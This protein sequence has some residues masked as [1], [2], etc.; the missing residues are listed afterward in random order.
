MILTIHFRR[1]QPATVI[2]RRYNPTVIDRRNPTVID[3]RN[4]TVID[5]RYNA[6]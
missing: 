5:R 4:P 3:R 1:R 2:D 6:S